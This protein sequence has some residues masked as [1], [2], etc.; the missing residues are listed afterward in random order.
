[1]VPASPLSLDKMLDA[2]HTLVQQDG[3]HMLSMRRL[4]RKLGVEPMAFYRYVGDR[5]RLLDA[6]VQRYVDR[7]I[8]DPLLQPAAD[9]DWRAFL[10][11]LGQGVRELAW[12]NPQSS[13]HWSPTRRPLAPTPAAIPALG[14][15]VPHGTTRERG[16]ADDGPVEA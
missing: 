11:H 9:H 8:E 3:P 7:M 5:G 2:A 14:R 4:G 16:F 1:M 6:L 12:P 13:R 15:A 10:T